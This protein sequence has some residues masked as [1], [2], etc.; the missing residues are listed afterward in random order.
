M[1]KQTS[2]DG[3]SSLD[4]SLSCDPEA[5]HGCLGLELAVSELLVSELMLV[6]SR[7]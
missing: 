7:F 6:K 5:S 4:E 3:I 2:C 1:P